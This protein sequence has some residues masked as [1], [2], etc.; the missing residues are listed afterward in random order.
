MKL[1]K[2]LYGRGKLLITGEYAVLD[3]ALALAIPT[4]KGQSLNVYDSG[5][6]GLRWISRVANEREPWFSAQL[7]ESG[8]LLHATDAEVGHRL[9]QLVQAAIAL[10][11]SF[12]RELHATEVQAELEFPRHWGLGSSSTLLY[13]LSEWAQVNSYR[14]ME[15]SFGKSGSGY[16]LACA[17]SDRSLIYQLQNGPVIEELSLDWPF[18]ENLLF[19]YMEQ[20]Q[21]SRQAIRQYR[22]QKAKRTPQEQTA[23][24]Q[25]VNALTRSCVQ[26]TSLT[27]FEM[28]LQQ[29]E[30]VLADFLQMGRVQDVRFTEY[31][32]G[33]IKSLGA[34]G[35]DFVLATTTNPEKSREYFIEKG[36]NTLLS[37]ENMLYPSL[38]LQE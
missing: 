1:R 16:D 2:T 29:H 3:G 8:R 21:D 18:A 31:S 10:N 15:N 13:T 20:K 37:A 32:D 5:E 11:P 38:S 12:K 23:F 6:T 34:W 30:E 14:L 22:D 27:E 33:L 9:E 4:K 19:V 7:D 35:G 28:V 25:T 24:I 36:Y 26:S 17:G